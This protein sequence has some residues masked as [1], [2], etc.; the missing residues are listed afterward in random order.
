MAGQITSIHL[1]GGTADVHLLKG[2]SFDL[3]NKLAVSNADGTASWAALPATDAAIKITFTSNIKGSVAG[4]VFS[5]NGIKIDTQNGIITAEAGA[6]AHPRQNF[7]VV[8]E[9]S[10]TDVLNGPHYIYI[11]FHVHTDIV[12][13]WLTPSSLTVRRGMT[14]VPENTNMKFSVYAQFDDGL[15]GDLT[16]YSSFRSP[17]AVNSISWTPSTHIQEQFGG[18]IKVPSGAAVGSEQ[19]ITATFPAS[20]KSKIAK[21]KIKIAEEWT[22]GKTNIAKKIGN[23]PGFDRR[24]D[25]PN[26]LFLSDGFQS[27]DG[28]TFERAVLSLVSKLHNEVLFQPLGVLQSSM[29]YWY[30]FT[31]SEHQGISN[32]NEYFKSGG[33]VNNQIVNVIPQSRFPITVPVFDTAFINTWTLQDVL[34]YIGL[35]APNQQD[36]TLKADWHETVRLDRNDAT[37]ETLLDALYART[38]L[39][40]QWLALKDRKLIDKKNTFFGVTAGYTPDANRPAASLQETLTLKTDRLDRNKLNAF[41]ST[42]VDDQNRSLKDLWNRKADGSNGKDFDL[43]VILTNTHYGRPVNDDGFFFIVAQ[44]EHTGVDNLDIKR[45]LTQPAGINT[46]FEVTPAPPAAIPVPN[47]RTLVHELSHSFNLLDEYGEG[48]TGATEAERKNE[49]YYKFPPLVNGNPDPDPTNELNITPNLQSE[50]DVT[51]LTGDLDADRIKWRW[52]RIEKAGVVGGPIIDKG[53]G[54][55]EIQLRSNMPFNF[56]KDEIVF[57]RLRLESGSKS[58]EFEVVS[59]NG[60]THEM[61]IKPT[62][63]GFLPPG[64]V[65]LFQYGAIVKSAADPKKESK[66]LKISTIMNGNFHVDLAA[67][68]KTYKSTPPFEKI[69]LFLPSTSPLQHPDQLTISK[70][71]KVFDH[72]T[73]DTVTIVAET[74]TA[75]LM[76]LKQFVR[77]SVL[78][79]PVDALPSVKTPAYKYSELIAK[80]VL[81]AIKTKKKP[82]TV[83][84]PAYDHG[85]IQMVTPEMQAAINYPASWCTGKKHQIVGLFSGGKMFHTGIYHPAGQCMMRGPDEELAKFCPVC[86]YALVDLIDPSQHGVIDFS[87]TTLYPLRS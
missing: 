64:I 54:K 18:Q 11:R 39:K 16:N 58:D 3:G 4:N 56:F 72:Q 9:A 80:N 12:H 79:K 87:I 50:S 65:L 24:N 17:S 71:L 86:Q 34:F 68:H 5:G 23:S 29:N 63:A 47:C 10:G 15:I 8:V 67:G 73:G 48:L 66:I 61:E 35:P 31:P 51:S 37:N 74:G 40:N 62:A 82:L 7:I 38:A 77:G 57:L 32:E 20:L 83:D 36:A 28:P 14:D 26:V 1:N 30:S 53:G 2:S 52:P 81:D 6:V 69:F 19:E 78:Y 46:W 43:I 45:D 55:F 84:P 41:L 85:S 22:T 42:L 44:V 27:G 49:V 70:P 21:A 33:G 13:Q 76:D 60:I 75:A 59:F 25:V